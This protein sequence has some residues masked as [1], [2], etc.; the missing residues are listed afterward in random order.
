M[1]A[2]SASSPHL[3]NMLP[4]PKE[5]NRFFRRRPLTKYIVRRKITQSKKDY[6]G[7]IDGL[8]DSMAQ[9][10]LSGLPGSINVKSGPQQS[11]GTK[12]SFQIDDPNVR[13]FYFLCSKLDV[14]AAI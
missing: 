6:E 3:T 10:I 11:S 5:N 8:V 1:I 4:S 12:W 2:A 7:E 13:F 14:M 9:H